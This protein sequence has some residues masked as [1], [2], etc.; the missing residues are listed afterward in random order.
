MLPDPILATLLIIPDKENEPESIVKLEG[1]LDPNSVAL[2][3]NYFGDEISVGGRYDENVAVAELTWPE[4]Q[5]FMVGISVDAFS[6]EEANIDVDIVTPYE[7]YK[8]MSF[9]LDH[10]VEDGAKL[11]TVLKGAVEENTGGWNLAAL[12]S[13]NEISISTDV[14][15]TGYPKY[16]WSVLVLRKSKRK[17]FQVVVK[18]GETESLL[19][20]DFIR[21][22]EG[23]LTKFNFH[24]CSFFPTVSFSTEL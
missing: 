6:F 15:I 19:D 9:S 2:V 17:S 1:N 22:D 3:V 5:K 4:N 7:G 10:K 8:T 24:G 12:I 23:Y 18:S 13:S 14:D 21:L 20:F 16:E 11:K